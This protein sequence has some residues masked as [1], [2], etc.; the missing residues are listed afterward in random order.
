VNSSISAQTNTIPA[1]PALAPWYRRVLNGRRLLLEH[2]GSVITFEGKAASLL[3][4]SLI[5]LLDGSRTVDEI[6]DAI[7]VTVAPATHRALALLAEK[8]VLLDGPQTSAVNDPVSES[9]IFVAAVGGATP[10][11]ALA[12]LSAAQ[13]IVA[14]TGSTSGEL[15]RV[16]D[17]AGLKVRTA[18]I[19][20]AGEIDGLLV[21]A[22]NDEERAALVHINK[23]CLEL[24]RPWL[25]ILPH[26]GHLV[27]IGPLFVPHSSA[28]FTCY[29]I[30][31]GACSGFEEDFEAI[32]SAALG[33]VS[34]A[35]LIAAAGGIGAVLALRWLASADP[36]IPG[37]VYT[38][39][40]GVVL[41]LGYH[42]VLRVPRCPAC[43]T[44]DGPMPAPWFSEKAR[45]G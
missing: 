17:A 23:R 25:Q 40:T 30:R 13:V 3:L 29:S 21:V 1:Q 33:A 36:T 18:D 9:A 26:D 10:A 28:C 38:L 27:V 8:G 20:E 31:R 15:V 6:V 11:E 2:G 41:G 34:P 4:P 22:P 5:E 44:G 32:E 12:K 16:L 45:S 37:R 39:E 43:G 7:G 19:S 35:P 14:G 24:G 42:H